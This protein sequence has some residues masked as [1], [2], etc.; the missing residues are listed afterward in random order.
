MEDFSKTYLDVDEL[1]KKIEK[2]I[3]ELEEK[4]KKRNEKLEYQND[5]LSEN[6]A[7]LDEIIAEI[8]KRIQE[9]DEEKTSDVKV[10]DLTN[11]VNEK[12]E[13]LEVEEDDL[14]KTIYDLSEI[15]K[16]INATIRELEAK[17]K[18]KKRKK[19]MYCDMARKNGKK[20]KNK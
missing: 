1:A 18:E 16:K 17:K 15:S 5:N 9:M 19:A 14:G 6:M 2:R 3:Q 8:D 10:D 7:N 11:K 13:N 12:L 20:K 4:E